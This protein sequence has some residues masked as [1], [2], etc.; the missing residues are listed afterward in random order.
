VT[1]RH[2]EFRDWPG[3][4]ALGALEPAERRAFEEHLEGCPACSDEVRSLLRVHGLLS[5][6]D[7][8]AIDD[9][10]DRHVADA[11]AARART[12]QVTE[13]SDLR[14]SRRRWRIAALSS[15]A[16]ALMIGAAGVVLITAG[17]EADS[18]SW[19]EG[20][21]VPAAITSTQADTTWI[22][23]SARGW[24]TEIHVDLLGLPPRPQYQLWVIDD[25]GVWTQSST[26]GPTPS[27]GAD[28]TGATSV[29]ADALDRIVVTSND[30]DEIL[31][32]A[33]V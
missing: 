30:R 27:G 4:Y 15:V 3:A 7:R 16:V 11:V 31:I 12:E 28:V 25:D 21:I 23:T 17:D 24:G 13:H 5:Q 32:D 10:P 1:D 6:L 18:P 9:R 2:D 8:T 20:P 19:A 22:S 14:S 33:R 29:A 26:W